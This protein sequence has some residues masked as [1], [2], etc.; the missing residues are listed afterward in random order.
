MHLHLVDRNTW[1]RERLFRQ[2]WQDVPCTYS[3]TVSLDIT[4]VIQA[5]DRIYPVM[6]HLLASVVNGHEAFKYGLDEEG[7][8]GIFDAVIP[9][10]TLFDRDTE[11][12]SSVITDWNGHYTDFLAAYESHLAQVGETGQ[13]RQGDMPRNIFY[14]SMIP[15]ETFTAF[16]LNLKNGYTNLAPVFTMGRYTK[17]GGAC[18]LPL[19]TQVHHAVCDGY[20]LCRMLADLRAALAAWPATKDPSS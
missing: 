19:A 6:I 2:Y 10:Y 18:F 15:W 3:M 14:I 4:P 5:G 8:I 12:F 13:E 16:H 20:H 9:S 17:E 1:K 7:N 11:L